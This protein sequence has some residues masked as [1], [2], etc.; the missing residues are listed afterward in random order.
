[1]TTEITGCLLCGLDVLSPDELIAHW[2]R[3]HNMTPEAA[4][5]VIKGICLEC[6]HNHREMREEFGV[7]NHDLDRMFGAGPADGLI[8]VEDDDE[9]FFP[10][11]YL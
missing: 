6:G 3:A 5:A 4:H 10:G 9:D 7:T 11:Q 2:D 1:M 8:L